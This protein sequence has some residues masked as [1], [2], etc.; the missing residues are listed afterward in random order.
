MVS[1]FHTFASISVLLWK[2]LSDLSSII[3]FALIFSPLNSRYCCCYHFSSAFT[4][5][6]KNKSKRCFSFDF[7]NHLKL[8]FLKKKNKWMLLQFFTFFFFFLFFDLE[9]FQILFLPTFQP[10]FGYWISMCA[11]HL[12]WYSLAIY[13]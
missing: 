7:I 2:Q 4:L 10:F 9:I 11:F 8:S 3:H 1:K 12:E 6:H 13:L 5:I